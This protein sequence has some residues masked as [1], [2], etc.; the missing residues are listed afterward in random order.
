MT[1]D[2]F[3]VRISSTGITHVRALGDRQITRCGVSYV[4]NG[5]YVIGDMGERP[6]GHKTDA[7]VDCMTCLV[8]PESHN[9]DIRYII[10]QN[11]MKD[12]QETE[13]AFALRFLM[14]A[15][16]KGPEE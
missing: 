5:Q 1:D 13:D 8:K 9:A 2:R 11:S 16:T 7:D 10:T 3:N 4:R 15:V 12:I 6:M 14:N